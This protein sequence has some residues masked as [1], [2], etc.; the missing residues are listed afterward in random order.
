MFHHYKKKHSVPNHPTYKIFAIMAFFVGLG[1]AALWT[2]FPLIINDII[3]NDKLI[4]VYYSVISITGLIASLLSTYLFLKYSKVLITKIT[5]SISILSLIG[6][7]IVQNIWQ[8][9]GLD[10]PRAIALTIASLSL[11]LFIADVSK[12]KELA[13]N[14][15]KFYLYS[16]FGWLIGPL[17]GGYTAKTFGNESVFIV[18]SIIFGIT[19]L[20]FLHQHLVI[21]N[22][23]L[24]D[25]K[26]KEGLKVII[27]N[28][29]NYFKEKEYRKVFN[30]ALGLN[31][32]WAISFL[33][34]P[35]AVE[36]MGFSQDIVGWVITG[37]I[38]P[39]VLLETWVGKIAD[40][41]GLKKYITFGF[42]FT[43]LITASF[44]LMTTTPIL[45]LI[46]F[47]AVNIGPAFIEP[48]QETYFFKAVKKKDED[49]YIGIY[50]LADP[51]ANIVGPTIG[52]GLIMI[53]NFNTIWIGTAII[54]L[55]FG[56]F[57]TTIKR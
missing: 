34:I 37:G 55:I 7:T 46:A 30:V 54:L 27:K 14:E 41:N 8:L 36:K 29:V 33:Y 1:N 43:A 2:I 40:R 9:G 21:K 35:L 39:L 50:N 19:L 24:H 6:M 45:L 4:G 23:H 38:I 17:L 10:I 49:K 16:N 5:L 18:T 52:A 32:W 3:N 15:G 47:A 44:T 26:E 48:L 25:E 51:I 53:G 13:S 28:T 12:K 57:S 20:Y 42:V 11:S 56:L 22:P 31:F